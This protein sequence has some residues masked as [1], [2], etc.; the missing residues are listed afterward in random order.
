MRATPVLIADIS[1]IPPETLVWVAIGLMFL[2]TA[3]IVGFLV[4]AGKSALLTGIAAGLGQI[5]FVHAYLGIIAAM[6]LG[7]AIGFLVGRMAGEQIFDLRPLRRHRPRI[8]AVTEQIRRRAWLGLLVGRSIAVLRA[9]TPAI[10]GV[11]GMAFR[12]FLLWNV[13]GAVVYT[14]VMVG[15]GYLGGSAIPGIADSG[16]RAVLVL[17]IA[18]LAGYV[19]VTVVRRRQASAQPAS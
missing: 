5:S 8:D 7:A 14:S 1:A 2:Q 3:L 11:S 18:V 9:T 16:P 6:V 19:V 12:Q 4:P 15:L 10:A 13:V 17:S